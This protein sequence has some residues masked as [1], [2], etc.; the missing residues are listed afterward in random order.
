MKRAYISAV[1]ILIIITA[2]VIN[3]YAIKN[4]S[5]DIK[6][7]VILS[8]NTND[9]ESLEH[10]HEIF[11][12]NH[13]YMCAVVYHN[14]IDELRLT[15]VRAKAFL[16]NEEFNHYKAEIKTLLSSLE[17]LKESERFILGNIF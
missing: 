16:E 13:S 14:E 9:K 15:F 11:K 4:V 5:N 17:H 1:V 10:A 3:L 7:K 12:K 8:L 2:S 6:E